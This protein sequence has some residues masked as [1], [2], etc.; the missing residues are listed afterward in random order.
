GSRISSSAPPALPLARTCT[1]A[2]ARRLT[3]PRRT[4]SSLRRARRPTARRSRCCIDAPLG[5]SLDADERRAALCAGAATLVRMS[6]RAGTST[7]V[8]AME[9]AGGDTTGEI[10]KLIGGKYRVERE[11]GSGGMGVVFE[12]RHQTLDELVAIKL[13]R[14]SAAYDTGATA[15]FL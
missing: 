15:R 13:L 12:A 7:T 6:D 11:L 9:P 4:S 5:R 14:G 8:P 10:G 1:A 2:R 3:A